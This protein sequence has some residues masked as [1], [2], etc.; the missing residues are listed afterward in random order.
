MDNDNTM[1]DTITLFLDD[2]SE[3]EC[4]IL[5]IF[6]AAGRDYIALLP[7]TDNSDDADSS[8]YIYRYS[9]DENEEPVLDNIVD[10][11][12]AE[13]VDEAFDEWL[14]EQEFDE[15]VDGEDI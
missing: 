10:D 1:Y 8:V 5:T 7:L 11:G 15:L 4:Q 14:D 9:E 2:G 3:V 6:E 12:E 13:L